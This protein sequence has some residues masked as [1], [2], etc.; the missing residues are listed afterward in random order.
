M[1]WAYLVVALWMVGLLVV[2]LMHDHDLRKGLKEL[3]IQNY[4]LRG[5][6]LNEQE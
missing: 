6:M 5:K 2:A 3:E 1:N 4:E